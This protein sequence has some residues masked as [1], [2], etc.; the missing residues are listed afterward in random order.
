MEDYSIQTERILLL[1]MELYTDI[2]QKGISKAVNNN[3]HP[4]MLPGHCYLV[5]IYLPIEGPSSY[6]Y[7]KHLSC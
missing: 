4:I 7:S 6:H 3:D 2:P 5:K 1:D